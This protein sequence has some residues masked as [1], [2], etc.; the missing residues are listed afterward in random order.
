MLAR[1]DEF[2][3]RFSAQVAPSAAPMLDEEALAELLTKLDDRFESAMTSETSA[4]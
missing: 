1:Y 4:R 3:V 2:V